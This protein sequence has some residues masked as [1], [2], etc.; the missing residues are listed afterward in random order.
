MRRERRRFEHLPVATSLTII[1]V[2]SGRRLTGSSINLS[3]GGVG[4]YCEKFLKPGT[5][6]TFVF[7]FGHGAKAKDESI[8][9]TV[10]WSKIEGDGAIGGAEFE[11]LLSDLAF[12]LLTDR[13]LAAI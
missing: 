8:G 10:R 11:A 7:H 3:R 1:D 12:P 5:H 4:F 2:Q 6:V 13:L 9:A